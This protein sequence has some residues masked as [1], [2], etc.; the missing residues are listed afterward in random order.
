MQIK[1]EVQLIFSEL[2]ARSILNSGLA[3]EFISYPRDFEITCFAVDDAGR[4]I[5]TLGP[6]PAKPDAG[7]G[8]A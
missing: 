7:Q 6:P 2:D 4:L 8:G 3:N 5:I 1:E